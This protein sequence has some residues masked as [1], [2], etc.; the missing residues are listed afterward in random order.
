VFACDPTGNLVHRDRLT[1]VGPTFSSR[2]ANEGR[3]FLAS[4]DNWFR[5][6]F[7]ATGPDGALY[8]A[9]MYRL[10]IEHPDYLPEEVRKRTDFNAGREMG[11]IWRVRSA[12]P[13]SPPAELIPPPVDAKHAGTPAV[14]EPS[15]ARTVESILSDL[16]HPNVWQRERAFAH[17][18]AGRQTHAIPSLLEKLRRVEE[19]GLPDFQVLSRRDAGY[20]RRDLPAAERV[21]LLQA[22]TVL[23]GRQ[24]GDETKGSREA[25]EGIVFQGPWI[26][27]LRAATTD[28]SPGVRAAAFRLL[29]QARPDKIECP[30]EMLEFWSRD[31]DPAVRFQVALV[32][33]NRPE[34]LAK[35][36]LVRIALPPFSAAS[37]ARRIWSA[38][39]CYGIRC[40]LHH[41][42]WPMSWDVTSGRKGRGLSWPKRGPLKT[43]KFGPNQM[44]CGK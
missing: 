27:C 7:L 24:E 4:R 2:M 25:T 19:T 15:P 3:E 41:L 31:P 35:A 20:F 43:L 33:G 10:T 13:E 36:A 21:Q 39:R 22:L 42:N 37:M 38:N 40:H 23:G 1:A 29:Q 6:V 28:T 26:S 8:V 34:P 14:T 9:D 18:L 5:P 11:R 30:G 44:P 32:L 16:G 12:L 17:L